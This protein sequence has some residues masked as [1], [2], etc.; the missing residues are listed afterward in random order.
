MSLFDRF[1]P[2]GGGEQKRK[3]FSSAPQLRRYSALDEACGEAKEQYPD[4]EK[5]IENFSW[6]L[7]E[8][9][10]VRYGEATNGELQPMK[11][12]AQFFLSEDRMSA[13]GCL[14]PPENG[15]EGITLEEFLEDM[16]YEGINYG[17]LQEEIR[18]EFE[19]GYLHIFQIARGRPPQTGAD[20]KVVELFKRRRTM[21]LEVQNGSQVD[22]GE[23]VQLQPIRKGTTICLIRPPKE[24][25]DGMDV[26]GQ[27]QSVRPAAKARVP[28]GENTVIGRG[29]QALIAE[30]DGILYIENDQ[31]CIH[32]QKIIDGDLDQFQG[33]LRVSG[34]LYVGGAA[35]GGVDIEASGDIV[36]NGKLGRAR[37]VSTGGTI[38]VQQGIFGTKGATCLT[39]ACQVQAPVMER[40]EID[41]GTSVIAD[42]ILD[43]TVRCGGT[44]YVMSGRGMIVDSRIQAGDSVLCL[45]IGNLA[46]GRSQVSAGYPPQIPELWKRLK[47]ELSEVQSVVE[48]LWEPITS[49]RKK[50]YRITDGE[51]S[52][53][54][55]LVE[56]RNLYMEKREALTAELKT[57][58]KE[59]DKKSRGRI[60][61]EKLYPSLS[62]QIGRLTEEITTTEEKC[63]IHV[64]DDRICL[65]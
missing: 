65:K 35:D 23:D 3:L 59:L 38:R 5:T 50:G 25:M 21:Q 64:E 22:F 1:V 40:A 32:E 28:Q 62:V 26:T 14:L 19:L 60:R 6:A 11:A 47:T 56:Q 30:V 24:G 17:I 54:E 7:K 57:L 45:R 20:G 15:G 58:D 16:H 33:T 12:S 43:S 61:C 18:R 9:S 48:K 4:D 34:N 39:A 36:I 13:F 31:F 10:R 51:R 63:D 2:K 44:V 46:G 53:L 37:V 8:A 29:G 55:Q 49:L 41:A 42:A 52:L 27:K